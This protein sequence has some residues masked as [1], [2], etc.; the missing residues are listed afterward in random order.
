M[1]TRDPMP[2][3]TP[4][5]RTLVLIA[6][7]LATSLVHAGTPVVTVRSVGA[8]GVAPSPADNDFLRLSQA[9]A[10]L[11]TGVN[12]RLDGTFDFSEP[13]AA[14]AWALGADASAGT[15]DDYS[16]LVPANVDGVV[17]EPVAGGT[18]VIQGPGDLPGANLEGFLVFDGG[19]NRDWTIRDLE[20]LDFDLGIGMFFG[21]GGSDAFD[22]TRIEGNRIR[23]P[24]DLNATVA[25]A[26]VNQNIGIHFAFGRN[27]RIAANLIEIPGNGRSDSANNRLASS[28]GMQSNTSGGAVYDGL[29]IA[30][31]IVRVTAAQSDD[32]ERVL[33]YWENS[34]GHLG[35]VQVSGNRFEN[36]AAGND[37]A[38]NRQRGFRVTSHSSATTT[39]SYAGNRVEG[40]NIGFEWIAGS[41]FA[42]NLPVRMRDNVVV[43]G[44]TGL[45]LQSNGL[46]DARC[47]RIAANA[48]GVLADAGTSAALQDNWW[49]C[50]AG[51]N[52]GLCDLVQGAATPSRWL[53]LVASAA[54][55]SIIEGGTAA[56]GASFP[57]YSDA[58][59][60]TCAF[61][62]TPVDF[63]ANGGSFA[64]ASAV[65]P[66][67][68]AGAA[69]TWSSGSFSGTASIQAVVDFETAPAQLR[70]LPDRLFEHGFED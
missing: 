65:M 8:D 43:G 5:P 38:R 22:G 28:V 67:P 4:R 66:D 33:G 50:N 57:R 31:N 55:A 69:T 23:L 12:L 70:V 47:N 32:A 6:L 21:A 20:I 52:A 51:P 24:A 14:A 41:N 2:P 11:T 1:L 25:P 44:G 46:V 56:V 54:P 40:A 10:A 64:P 48:L 36:L 53:I 19:K 61:A 58:A 35:N 7:A 34:H 42:G 17:L 68:L 30:D 18:A 15:A 63:I 49:G 16:V 45:R 13:N 3:R 27:Q 39:V 59:P 9:V 62:D 29:V 60:A 37:P 26:D